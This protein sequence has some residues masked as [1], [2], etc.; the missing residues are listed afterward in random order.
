MKDEVSDHSP[1]LLDFVVC[2]FK[3]LLRN[4]AYFAHRNATAD[5]QFS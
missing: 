1:L 3:Y 4:Q 5:S 2:E